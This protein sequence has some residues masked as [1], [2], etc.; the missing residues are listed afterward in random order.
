MDK[1]KITASEVEQNN[2]KS[3]PTHIY[4]SDPVENKHIF[5][6][7]PELIVDKFNSFLA[8]F[9]SLVDEKLT[10]RDVKIGAGDMLQAVYDAD[11][12]GIV[13]KAKSAAEAEK[14][15]GCGA[16]YFASAEAVAKAQSAA[17]AAM[18]KSGGEFTG[19]VAACNENRAA[20]ELR[21]IEVR[22]TD[23]EGE[24]QSTNKIIM[25]RK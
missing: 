7:L 22:I 15:G 13:D 4:G 11:D 5:D 21:N 19:Y 23:T 1:Y 10:E 2:V 17:D 25:V 18:P 8:A 14:L 9:N 3:A 20:S 6:K 24:M 16:E 12:D